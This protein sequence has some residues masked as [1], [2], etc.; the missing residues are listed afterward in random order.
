[1]R[2]IL[3]QA[4]T[5]VV[6][7]DSPMKQRLN[8]ILSIANDIAKENPDALREF[9]RLLGRKLQSDYMCR[10]VSIL[11]EHRM[12]NL[13][14]KLVWFDEFAPLNS[15][16]ESVYD[17]KVKADTTRTLRLAS[18]LVLP[19]PWNTSRVVSNISCIGLGRPAGAWSQDPNHQ[20]EYWLPFGIGWVYGGNH[21]IMTGIVRGEGEIITDH[22]YD[23]SKIFSHVRFNGDAFIRISD[24]S[25][26]Q[27]VTEFEF[28]AIFE[29]GRLMHEHGISA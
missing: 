5:L 24:G 11:D 18:D 19:W 3:E 10:A 4:K 25:V 13:E 22:I 27:K 16:G 9:V 17:L 1:M 26:I 23:L 12:P 14:P 29:I 28:A 15:A 21:S 6:R 20:V 2:H 8:K 7:K